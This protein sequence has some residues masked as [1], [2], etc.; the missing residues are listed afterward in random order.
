MPGAGSGLVDQRALQLSQPARD[1]AGMVAEIQPQVGRDLVVA[2]AAGPQLA[3]QR[4][5]PFQ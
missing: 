2:A 3:A 1:E 5:E 4:A